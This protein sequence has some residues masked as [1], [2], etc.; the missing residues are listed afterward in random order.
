MNLHRNARLTPR[1]RLLLVERVL[2][3]QVAPYPAG[4]TTTIAAD[5]TAASTTSHPSP[6]SR[7]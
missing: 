1:G 6:A 2:L 4:S 3:G 5:H 7:R